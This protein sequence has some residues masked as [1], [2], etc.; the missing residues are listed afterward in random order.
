MERSHV[1]FAQRRFLRW[2]GA[3]GLAASLALPIFPAAAQPETASGTNG[4]TASNCAIQLSVANP[5]PGNQE[6]PFKLG[7]SGTA[8]DETAKAG[9]GTGISRVQAFLGNR[10]AGGTFV[11]QADLTQQQEGIPGSWFIS[12]SFHENA[13]GGQ[14]VFVYALSS[15][16]G[17]EAVV[18]IPIAFGSVPKD[19]VSTEAQSFCPVVMAP[20][21]PPIAAGL[22]H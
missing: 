4:A 18:T 14:N 16:S 17:Q 19:E 10:D 9:A 8:M 22:V 6:I 20:T 13:I 15:V 7:M 1:I 2:A 21:P 5:S 3:I 11:G 12:A